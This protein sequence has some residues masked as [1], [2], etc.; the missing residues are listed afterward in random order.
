MKYLLYNYLDMVQKE[1]RAKR[2]N[3]AFEGKKV[4]IPVKPLAKFVEDGLKSF[5]LELEYLGETKPVKIEFVDG[6]DGE[7]NFETDECRYLMYDG[8]QLFAKVT[9]YLQVNDEEISLMGSVSW[10][11]ED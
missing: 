5:L 8:T 1:E 2:V 6:Y 10:R 9:G 4:P 7:V 3:E 11:V